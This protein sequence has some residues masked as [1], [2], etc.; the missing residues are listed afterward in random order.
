MLWVPLLFWSQHVVIDRG[1]KNEGDWPEIPFF[2]PAAQKRW[3]KKRGY[4]V[5]ARSE[6]LLSTALAAMT[7]VFEFYYNFLK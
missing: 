4:P 6:I 3:V 5:K 2:Y 7:I 1:Q